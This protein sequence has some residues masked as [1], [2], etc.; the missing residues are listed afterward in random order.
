MA[1]ARS[2]SATGLPVTGSCPASAAIDTSRPPAKHQGATVSAAQDRRDRDLTLRR[3]AIRVR[4]IPPLPPT[5]VLHAASD[6]ATWLTKTRVVLWRAV[7][8]DPLSAGR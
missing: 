4:T 3:T 7:L 8:A 1:G 2:V 6:L 5:T